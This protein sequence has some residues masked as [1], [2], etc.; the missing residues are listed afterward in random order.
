MVFGLW[1]NE[2]P[3]MDILRD[4]IPLM[5]YMEQDGLLRKPGTL[6]LFMCSVW[7]VNHIHGIILTY[8]GVLMWYLEFNIYLL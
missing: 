1:E 4:L 5:C 8:F 2:S 6:S 7:L 3:G